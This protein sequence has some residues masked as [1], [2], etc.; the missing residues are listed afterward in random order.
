MLGNSS[1]Q[2]DTHSANPSLAQELTQSERLEP[3]SPPVQELH[4]LLQVPTQVAK[5]S[6]GQPRT[7][8]SRSAP[9]HPQAHL[10]AHGAEQVLTQVANES[11][12]QPRTQDSRSASV[13]PHVHVLGIGAGGVGGTGVGGTGVGGVG[14]GGVSGV[15]VCRRRRVG[16]GGVGGG[17]AGA[18]HLVGSGPCT[19]VPCTTRL[20]TSKCEVSALP[21]SPH[22]L[23][24]GTKPVHEED[25]RTAPA[26]WKTRATSLFAPSSGQRL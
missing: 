23:A 18:L 14:G 9:V 7:Q 3:S 11:V 1:V 22:L 10:P 5:E 16:G 20:W 19:T 8:D 24:K 15:G 26:T 25:S 17:G 6:A 12:G 4:G 21:P 2:H 13:H